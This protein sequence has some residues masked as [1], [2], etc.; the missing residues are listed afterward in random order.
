MLNWTHAS[1]ALL[2]ALFSLVCFLTWVNHTNEEVTSKRTTTSLFNHLLK[3]NLPRDLR[4]VVNLML[5]A[6]AMM[7]F[8][9]PY[10][11]ALETMEQRLIY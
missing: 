8:P 9:L 10:F 3:D 5:V 11:S 1:A 4:F 6:K 7:S 2:K